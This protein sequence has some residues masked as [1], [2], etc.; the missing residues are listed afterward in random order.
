MLD[1]YRHFPDVELCLS[2]E[3]FNGVWDA[4]ADERVEVAIG[5]TQAVPV[6]GRYAFRDMGALRWRCVVSHLHPLA[7]SRQK[8]SDEQLRPWPSLVLED[9]SRTLPKRV[10][11][12]LDN[13]RR[14]VVPDW[15]SA[16]DCINAGL[17][18]GMVPAHMA[19]PWIESGDW[20]VLQLE[21][22]FPDAACCVSWRQD[23]PSPALNWLLAYLGDSETL[24]HE[25]LREP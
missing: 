14:I 11:W 1:F 15:A 2:K 4:L 8:L 5:A 24:N 23:N 16:A 7:H 13:Q 22:P 20:R 25:W 3:V 10:T 18:T 21:N 17:C 19:Q 12:L 6:G 9:T